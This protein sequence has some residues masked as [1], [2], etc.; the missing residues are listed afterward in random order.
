M[1]VYLG[2]KDTLVN[3]EYTLDFIEAHNI[4]CDIHTLAEMEHRC[5]LNNFLE[6][7]TKSNF[8]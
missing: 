8:I 5:N 4:K 2:E 7:L 1:E 6:I 3:K